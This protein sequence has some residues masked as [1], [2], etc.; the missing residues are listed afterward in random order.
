MS[1]DPRG[2]RF[3]SPAI[4]A[5]ALVRLPW[6]LGFWSLQQTL[7][8]ADPRR[9]WRQ[10]AASL[11]ELSQAAQGSLEGPLDNLRKAGDQLQTGL[12]DSAARLASGSWR[13]PRTAIADAWAVLGRSWSSLA[14]GD[15][16]S[17]R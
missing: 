10:T 11:D 2:D 12:I 6:T 16:R 17:G 13:E 9:P 7:D 3:R 4:L 8:L 15:R 1:H 5:Q 14:D